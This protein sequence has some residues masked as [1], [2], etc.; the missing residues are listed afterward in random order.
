MEPLLPPLAAPGHGD[1]IVV[2]GEGLSYAELARAASAVAGQVDGRSCVA[3]WATTS[4]ETC[5]AVV[6]AL[7]AGVPVVPLN[8][9][10]GSRELAHIVADAAPSAVLGRAADELPHELAAVER[11]PVPMKAPGV[12]SFDSIEPEATAIILYTSGTTGPPKGVEIPCRAIA[13]NLDALAELWEWT[14]ADRLTHA[15]PLFHVH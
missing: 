11:I 10:A 14:A 12:A 3:V 6:G 13:T 8:P 1:A 2:A 5:V 9:Q 7:A 15:L 4:L